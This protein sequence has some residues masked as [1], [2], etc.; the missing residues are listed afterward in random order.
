LLITN[1]EDDESQEPDKEKGG[2]NLWS[3]KEHL[4]LLATVFS[5]IFIGIRLL[6]ISNQNFETAEGILQSSGTATVIIGALVPQ[7]GIFTFVLGMGI[8]GLLISGRIDK[9]SK[10]FATVLTILLIAASAIIAPIGTFVAFSGLVLLLP[11]WPRR[12]RRWIKPDSTSR[13]Q[14][15]YIYSMVGWVMLIIVYVAANP[16]PWIPAEIIVPSKATPFTGY[17]LSQSDTDVAILTYKNRQIVHMA[18]RDIVSQTVCRQP[19]VSFRDSS[20]ET[21]PMLIYGQNKSNY[22]ACPR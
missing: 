1:H 6:S 13:M 19:G 9:S 12:F 18:P 4:P 14:R 8:G 16:V 15:L 3:W 5:V 2:G 22:P 11:I 10:Q 20:G 21:L 7:T 17:V